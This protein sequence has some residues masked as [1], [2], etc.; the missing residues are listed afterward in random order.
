MSR[1]AFFTRFK[2]TLLQGI[3]KKRPQERKLAQQKDSA[4]ESINHW[5]G[6][7]LWPAEDSRARECLDLPVTFVCCLRLREL[8]FLSPSFYTGL[9]PTSIISIGLGVGAH[10]KLARDGGTRNCRVIRSP[11]CVLTAGRFSLPDDD[12]VGAPTGFSG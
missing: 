12:E 8:L 4:L 9:C 10:V 6:C 7:D 5:S 2:P 3:E 1:L 11:K